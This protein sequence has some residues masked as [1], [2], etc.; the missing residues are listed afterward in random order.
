MFVNSQEEERKLERARLT[1]QKLE[2]EMMAWRSKLLEHKKQAS[3]EGCLLEINWD[4][5]SKSD[6]LLAVFY[7]LYF[8]YVT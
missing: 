4:I 8:F 6:A 3:L 5:L 2:E 1:Q 7:L